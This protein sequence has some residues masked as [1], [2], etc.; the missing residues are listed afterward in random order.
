MILIVVLL[1][2]IISI[3]TAQQNLTSR[4][5]NPCTSN[6]DCVQGICDANGSSSICICNR[7]WSLARDGSNQCTYQQ[8]SKLAAFLLSFFM[9]GLGA[10]WFYLSVGNGGY[11]AAGVFKLLTLGGIGIWWLVDWIR[12]LTN[13][14][15]D[16]QGVGLLEWSP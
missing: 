11:I 8:K 15:L 14:F 16:G 2:L 9:G 10:D 12:V 1:S 3:T 4:S 7:G 6:F 13:A 5:F